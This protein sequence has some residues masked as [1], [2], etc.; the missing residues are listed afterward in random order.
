MKEFN[1]ILVLYDF[2]NDGEETIRRGVNLAARNKA[3]LTILSVIENEYH[4]MDILSERRKILQNLCTWTPVEDDK[5]RLIVKQGNKVEEAVS[6]IERFDIDLVITSTETDEQGD[7]LIGIDSPIETLKSM[8]RPIW[9]VRPGSAQ[10]YRTVLVCVNA[11][12]EDVMS[13]KVN[14]HLIEL[15][16]SL[17]EME[18]AELK[19]LYVWD[20]DTPTKERLSSE[21]GNK[22]RKAICEDGH[23]KALSSLVKLIIH[24]LGEPMK[25]TPTVKQGEVETT[26]MEFIEE[27]SPDIFISDGT[28][29]SPLADAIMGN[30]GLHILNSSKCSTLELQSHGI[31]E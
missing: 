9:V 23:Y 12:K 2:E 31:Q 6:Y 15:G 24:V 21:L 30:C 20:Y 19:V 3:D 26:I 7:K 17:A 13:C 16:N 27:T 10:F 29:N 1:N 4:S 25:A 14:K 11:G 22:V 8:D 5:L 18:R 28:R